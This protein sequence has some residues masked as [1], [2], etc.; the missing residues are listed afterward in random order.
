[1]KIGK[2]GFSLVELAIFIVV[3]GLL[4]IVAMKFLPQLERV[5][6]AP[7]RLD[8]IPR[9]DDA[10]HGFI[11]ANGRLPCP[12]GNGDG[13][14]DCTIS[15]GELPYRTLGMAAP[16]LNSGRISYRYS[17]FR[18]ANSADLS[19]DVDLAVSADRFYPLLPVI[20]STKL[21]VETPLGESNSVD[22]CQAL[23][24]G[25]QGVTDTTVLYVGTGATA[26]NVAYLIADP[27]TEDSN[28]DGDLFDGVNN[29]GIG[30][31]LTDRVKSIDYDDTVFAVDFNQLYTRLGCAGIASPV[32]HGHPN[33][34]LAVDIMHDSMI[35]Y[36]DQLDLIAEL[37]EAKV[38]AAIAT[39]LTA[40]AGIANAA[41]V[42][43][44]AIA[45]NIL[46][47]G[48]LSHIIALAAAAVTANVATAV[49]TAM[50]LGVT[51][52]AR[53]TANETVTCFDDGT[54]CPAGIPGDMVDRSQT[55]EDSIRQNVEDADAAGLY[56]R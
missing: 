53:D 34:A 28:N 56:I 44:I 5:A 40:D 8:V 10:I 19:Q 20:N 55:L 26:T 49:E 41:S 35:D 11:Y 24:V 43:A 23:F 36:G 29:T 46:A 21:A 12:D 54:D 4:T 15:N 32:V 42:S 50:L 6:L 39:Q 51:E 3:L 16:A 9:I 38:E 31:E 48:A 33:V 7:K 1:M 37:A 22:F 2:K 27:G 45:Q 17:V 25:V 30:W 14:E 52:D 18:R 13:L 47:H